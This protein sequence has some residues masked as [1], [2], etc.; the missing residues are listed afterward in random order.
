MDRSHLPH[1]PGRHDLLL[2]R[3]DQQWLRRP[4]EPGPEP[5]R[6]PF[7]LFSGL[8]PPELLRLFQ[9]VPLSP[10]PEASTGTH[11]AGAHRHPGLQKYR[12]VPEV[13]CQIRR[14]DQRKRLHPY[15]GGA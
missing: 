6:F 1:Q 7:R 15:Q 12:G 14:H 9:R 2:R 13:V 10:F 4:E 3:D 11:Q 5:H 8:H